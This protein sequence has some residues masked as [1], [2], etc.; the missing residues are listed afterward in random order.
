MSGF[1]ICNIILI[2]ISL[3]TPRFGILGLFISVP[4]LILVSL[5]FCISKHEYHKLEI[6]NTIK[7]KKKLYVYANLMSFVAWVHLILAVAVLGF[8]NNLFD[9]NIPYL[10]T[11]ISLTSKEIAAIYFGYLLA[12]ICI[13]VI[14][15]KKIAEFKGINNEN[16]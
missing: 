1:Y 9:K 15:E 13:I 8:S 5:L 4:L 6:E 3:S 12:S 2:I 11:T 16:N 14:L 10:P 7:T